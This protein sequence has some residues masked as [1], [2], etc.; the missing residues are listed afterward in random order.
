QQ[1]AGSV[2]QNVNSVTLDPDVDYILQTRPTVQKPGLPSML[3]TLNPR[4]DIE[5]LQQSDASRMMSRPILELP[6]SDFSTR[7]G[8]TSRSL[9]TAP[10]FEQE[11]LKLPVRDLNSDPQVLNVNELACMLPSSR[12]S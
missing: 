8:Q 12:N 2:S 9:I 1:N 3:Q 10:I 4:P 5:I 11:R 7:P 6:I